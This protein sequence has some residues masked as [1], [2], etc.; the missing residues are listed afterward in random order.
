VS[1][2]TIWLVLMY[3]FAVV[4]ETVSPDIDP[5]NLGIL[6]HCIE[7]GQSL[8]LVS[9]ACGSVERLD[10]VLCC[11]VCGVHSSRSNVIGEHI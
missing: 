8:R 11:K 2:M 7:D 9:H 1:G 5:A 6:T 4:K 10:D 3:T